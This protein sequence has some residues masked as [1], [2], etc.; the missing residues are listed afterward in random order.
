MKMYVFHA[1][2]IHTD[3]AAMVAGSASQ[4]Y[5]IPVPYFLIEHEKGY[6]LFDTGH[7][8][9][10]VK[11]VKSAVTEPI[12]L[13][14]RPDAYEEGYVL[15]ALAKAG[16]KP[17]Q[18]SYVICSHLHFDHC[19]GMGFFPNAT[20]VIQKRE[21]HY[22][23]VPDPF[24]KFAYF[25]EDFD[26]DLNWL[27]LDGWNDKH[28]D[29]FGDGK[30]IIHF[31]PGHTPGHQSL[32]VNLEKEGPIM[33]TA[34]A[35]YASDN[36][37]D[38]KLSGIVNDNAAYMANIMMFRDMRKRGIKIFL[39]HDPEQWLTIKKFPEFYS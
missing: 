9:A 23:Y 5:D 11:D 24:I 31:T 39:G 30:L 15:N 32:L 25:R 12:Y 6:V 3:K 18:I 8:L 22:A 27:F 4:P 33:L 19:G 13:A 10:T 1:S 14:F 29:L 7:N 34:D 28:Y 2:T 36:L 37:N 17:E 35:C 20:Y 21:L 38:L 16:V 26:K